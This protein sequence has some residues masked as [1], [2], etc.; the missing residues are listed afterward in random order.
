MVPKNKIDKFT[1]LFVK[2]F[3]PTNF[4]ILFYK[5]IQSFELNGIYFGLPWLIVPYETFHISYSSVINV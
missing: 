5:S 3:L 1:S 4:F 2:L